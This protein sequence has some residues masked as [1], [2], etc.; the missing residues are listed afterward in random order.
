MLSACRRSL[1]ARRTRHG[2]P[3]TVQERTGHS[4]SAARTV[5]RNQAGPPGHVW[6]GQVVL[7]R[8]IG[9]VPLTPPTASS[10]Q[11]RVVSCGA[12]AEP[13]SSSSRP[14][15]SI[16]VVGWSPGAGQIVTEL[17]EGRSGMRSGAHSAGRVTQ[18]ARQV[19]WT[20]AEQLGP[21]R[22][23]ICDHDRK[24]TRSLDDMFR[25][26]GIRIVRTIGTGRIEGCSCLRCA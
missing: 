25:G 14:H 12:R 13:Y 11:P 16:G 22:V 26:A 19:A 2:Q 9:R 3:C 7:R 10:S 6:R 1:S 23:L 8:Q 20:I 18:Q 17:A 5:A 21:T 15:C 24:F 4:A